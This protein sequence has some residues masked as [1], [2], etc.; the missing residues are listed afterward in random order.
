MREDR[1]RRNMHIVRGD[2]DIVLVLVL[3]LLVTNN[4]APL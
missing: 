1:S 4:Y 3:M 2:I